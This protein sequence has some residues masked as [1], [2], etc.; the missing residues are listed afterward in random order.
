[1]SRLCSERFV[2]FLFLSLAA[3]LGFTVA[4]EAASPNAATVK[5]KR[6]AEAKGYVFETS[7]DEI[8][9]KAKKEGVLR[10]LA[11]P[12]PTTLAPLVKAFKEK[13]PFIDARAAEIVREDSQTRVMQ[14]KSG[15][16]LDEDVIHVP[17]DLYPDYLPYLKK[18][19][20]VAMAEHKVLDIPAKM[21]DSIHLNLVAMESSLQVVAFNKCLIDPAKVP[22]SWEDFLKPEFKGKKYL[23]DIRPNLE[24]V[25]AAGA[26]VVV[27]GAAA[28]GQQP[29]LTPRRIVEMIQARLGVPWRSETVDTFKAG[30]PDTTVRGI[31]TT[32]MATMSVLERAAAAGRNFVISHEP[33]FYGHTD[34][35]AELESD[36][37]Y[38][39]KAEL[40]K[41]HDLVVWR[42]HDHWHMRRPEPM[43][44]GFLRA[45][46]WEQYLQESSRI[47]TIP[48]TTV[49]A[50]ARRAE[51]R[52][53]IKALRVLGDPTT[54]VVKV[55]FMP[56]YGQLPA[57]VRNLAEADL[58]FTGEQREWEG[59]YYA[60]DAIASGR[61][62]GV[63]V[64]GHAVSEEPGMEICAEWL[65]T[66]ITQVPIELIRAGEP[67]W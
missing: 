1:M 36:P 3:W 64:L 40:I 12:S 18:F 13:Y 28:A 9:A 29:T 35:T 46:G 56:G 38:Q 50:A 67:F 17:P 57:L 52:L 62:K 19:D 58:V 61:A 59:L 6:D 15:S 66:F 20:I 2:I 30:N 45:M 23:V 42:F 24:T 21:I 47:I 34:A 37:I 54:K 10:V 43:T 11:S 22:S 14:L 25:M 8:V 41:K 4:A 49:G 5:A 31:A 33:T 65:K 32:V 63:I 16:R 53:G 26:G 51:E 48:E 27:A 44:Q 60:H 39:R 55:A 7:R